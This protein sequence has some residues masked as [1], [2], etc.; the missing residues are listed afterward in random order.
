MGP[1]SSI[2]NT[3]RVYVEYK[4]LVLQKNTR[5]ISKLGYRALALFGALLRAARIERGMSQ[6]QLA[7]RLGVSRHTVIALEQGS[8]KVAIGTAFEAAVILG[9]PL[10]AADEQGVAK[11]AGTLAALATVLPARAGRKSA[12]LNDEF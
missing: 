8:P 2:I 9:I 4:V 6:A 10:L 11:L 7:E 1:L 3:N 12:A 5:P